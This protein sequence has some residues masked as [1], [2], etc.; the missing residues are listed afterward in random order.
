MQKQYLKNSK[1]QSFN[2]EKFM[3]M[4][5]CVARHVR[6]FSYKSKYAKMY[7]NTRRRYNILFKT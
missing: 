2:A 7:V 6:T 4:N 3:S 5:A 1:Y